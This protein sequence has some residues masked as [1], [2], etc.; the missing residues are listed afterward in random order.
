[1]TVTLPFPNETHFRV[2][3]KH[4]EESSPDDVFFYDSS[5]GIEANHQQFLQDVYATRQG[6][7]NGL[8]R[9][10]FNDQ[11]IIHEERPFICLLNQGNYEYIVAAFAVLILGGAVV[12][13]SP[14]ILPEEASHL[15]KQCQSVVL[16]AGPSV[17]DHAS[18]IQQYA[19][20]QQQ[21]IH[22]RSI[23]IHS[24]Q[25]L[26]RPSIEEAMIISPERPSML[27]FTSGT[28]GPPKGVVHARRLL[29]LPYTPAKPGAYL[30]CISLWT[31]GA[32]RLIKHTLYA[33][34]IEIIRPD[35][36]I[37][38]ERLRKGGA[39]FLAA[40]IPVW[41]ALMEYF[42]QNL[43]HLP[44]AQRE[45][46]LRGLRG[47]NTAMVTGGTLIRSRLRFWSDLG[48][49]LKLCYGVTELGRICL[50]TRNEVS[51][52]R[53]NCLGQ[54][55][56]GT[57]IKLSEGDY[58][59][60]LIKS[61]NVFMRYLNNPAA[62]KAAF[63]DDGFYRTG[64]MV[65]REDTDYFFHGRA[66]TDFIKYYGYQIPI[67]ALEQQLNELPWVRE[68]YILSMPDER[69]GYRAAALIRLIKDPNADLQPATFDLPN[70]RAQL[71]DKIAAFMLPTAL[72]FLQEEETVPRTISGK[73]IR[74]DAARQFF[75]WARMDVARRRRYR[76]GWRGHR[77][78][79]RV[80]TGRGIGLGRR[81]EE[82][83]P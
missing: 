55:V 6:L 10:L 58:G 14:N 68:G 29:D 73:I 38:W 76:C 28:V 77:C 62:T 33:R 61:P 83:Q 5:C 50:V 12:P 2:L 32:V 8:P 21:D 36:G 64:D 80:S 7:L 40:V 3:L 41:Q 27:V 25:Q 20:S 43:D 19:L 63:T 56:L 79:G 72:R 49:P 44:A 65:S 22:V 23:S 15:M 60:L 59:E 24:P 16:M 45:E 39:A 4:C 37:L 53:N 34:R 48:K 46:Y 75:P 35:P 81:C 70:L 71:T 13:L 52:D 17:S 11:D 47:L 78:V 82:D 54:P 1:M 42:Q 66:S 74:R 18:A 57:T 67:P 31:V 69:C 9:V 30:N 26:I 51:V